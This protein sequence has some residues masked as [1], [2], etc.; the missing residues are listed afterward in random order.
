VLI[1][2]DR[3][4]VTTDRRDDGIVVLVVVV[5]FILFFF[6]FFFCWWLLIFLCTIANLLFLSLWWWWGRC[7][8]WWVGVIWSEEDDS[9]LDSFNSKRWS[10]SKKNI[11]CEAYSSFYDVDDVRFFVEFCTVVAHRAWNTFVCLSVCLL[12]II[13]QL[14]CNHAMPTSRLLVG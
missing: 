14:Q 11:S 6:F 7:V 3:C 2:D 9:I 12:I 13:N 1:K 10:A 4:F 8:G 5:V